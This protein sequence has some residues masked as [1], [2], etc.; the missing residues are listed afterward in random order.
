MKILKILIF[1]IALFLLAIVSIDKYSKFNQEKFRL[2]ETLA[3]ATRDGRVLKKEYDRELKERLRLK[4]RYDVTKEEKETLQAEL[5]RQETLQTELV[6]QKTL[7]EELVRK[8][9]EQ[10]ALMANYLESLKQDRKNKEELQR[11]NVELQ[12]E[13]Q[14]LQK[15]KKELEQKNLELENKFKNLEWINPED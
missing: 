2:K 10:Q 5:V 12:K 1:F 7:K 9:K 15:E 4:N 11:E 3:G 6:K 13:K 14:E 8:D